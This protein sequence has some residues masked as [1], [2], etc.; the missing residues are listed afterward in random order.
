LAK[1]VR[2]SYDINDIQ[3]RD[4]RRKYYLGLA[5]EICEYMRTQ[6]PGEWIPSHQISSEMDIPL[7]TVAKAVKV[8]WKVFQVNLIRPHSNHHVV[9]HVRLH[10]DV[11]DRIDTNRDF[12]KMAERLVNG[13]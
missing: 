4:N 5:Y 8:L 7:N 6:P 13:R 3:A 10:P 2:P 11:D 12:K 1:E 9:L